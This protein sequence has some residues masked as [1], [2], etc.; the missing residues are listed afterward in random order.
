MMNPSQHTDTFEL[1]TCDEFAK[2]F[3]VTRTIIYKWKNDGTL[4]PGRH[5]IKNG[6]VVRYI[7][8]LEVIREIH[9]VDE[10][11]PVIKDEL[12]TL[13]HRDKKCPINLDY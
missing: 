6:R 1:L 3:G 9:S 5:F 11:P 12:K 13:P 7:W 8:S 2:R 10:Q 4:V